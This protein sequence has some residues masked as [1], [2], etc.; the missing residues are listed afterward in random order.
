[1]LQ[2]PDVYSILTQPF[3]H[4]TSAPAW[5]M[6]RDHGYR[7]LMES[8]QM[9]YLAQPIQI[10]DHVMTIGKM[11]QGENDMTDDQVSLLT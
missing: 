1:M 10:M 3:E 5:I 7:I 9:F 8:F 4:M 2:Q 6:W 11:K